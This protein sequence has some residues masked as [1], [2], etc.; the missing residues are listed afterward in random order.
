MTKT[1]EI[2]VRPTGET[3][4]QT[5]GFAGASCREASRFI[6]EALGTLWRP[7]A[8]RRVFPGNGTTGR[9]PTTHLGPPY[10]LVS[11]VIPTRHTAILIGA[12][13][14]VSCCH[15]DQGGFRSIALFPHPFFPPTQPTRSCPCCFPSSSTSTS[16]P[17]SPGCGCSRSST[18][19]RSVRSVS[20]VTNGPGGWPSG[21]LIGACRSPDKTAERVLKPVPAIRWP[22]SEHST[23]SPAPRARRSWCCRTST[24]SW[25]R[26]K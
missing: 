10:L 22:L 9:Q 12:P 13:L 11:I 20:F 23:R 24:D 25:D 5:K 14:R 16:L 1:I 15:V 26:R 18:M 6:E 17:A 21:T 19:T 3:S 8:H 2:I 7:D 4:V